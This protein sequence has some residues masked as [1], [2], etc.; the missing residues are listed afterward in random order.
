MVQEIDFDA[1]QIKA[2]SAW[3]EGFA[4][5]V[6]G[7]L[8][9][10]LSTK[11]T[12]ATVMEGG[13]FR[14]LLPAEGAAF[15]CHCG[16][17]GRVLIV[18]SREA[19]LLLQDNEGLSERISDGA[20]L[21]DEE[22]NKVSQAA[23][24][25]SQAVVTAYPP[26]NGATLAPQ[27]CNFLVDAAWSSGTDPLGDETLVVSETK[28]Q[29][30]EGQEG[31][32]WILCSQTLFSDVFPA[33]LVIDANGADDKAGASDMVFFSTSEDLRQKVMDSLGTEMQKCADLADLLSKFSSAEASGAIVGI[34]KGEEYLLATLRGLME[35]PECASKSMIVLLEEP[36]TWNVV[37][38][39]RLGIYSVLGQDFEAPELQQ[40]VKEAQEASRT[41]LS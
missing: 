40:R 23:S 1:E 17:D 39:G 38:C 12:A 32:A 11:T 5:Q 33:A 29:A 31:K 21:S 19:A 13:A 4:S 18:L 6:I 9:T 41:L 37:R 8:K 24:L 27:A 15:G 3:F 7:P 36:S 35:L 14:A 30:A 22:Q 34:A 26:A 25:A 10:D 28:M 16:S 20:P 2:L